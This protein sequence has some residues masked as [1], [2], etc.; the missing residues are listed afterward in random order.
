MIFPFL[1]GFLTFSRAPITWLIIFI[2][3]FLFSQNNALSRDVQIRFDSWYQNDDFLYTQG[4]VY[5]QYA[6]KRQLAQVSDNKMVGRLAFRDS[7]F[8]KVALVNNWEGDQI[9]INKW[10][11]E[12]EEFM[13]LRAYYPAIFLGLSDYQKD[14]FSYLSYQFYHDGFSHLLGNILLL[15]I[16]GG[17]L[18][19]RYSGLSIFFIYL[20]GGV[21]SAFL[22]SLTQGLGGAPVVGASGSLCALLGFL[23]A[24]EWRGKTRLFY[25]ILPAKKYMG[26]VFIPTVYWVL[27]LLM[28]DDLSGAWAQSSLFSSGVAYL[29]HI[30]GFLFGLAIGFLYQKRHV[31]LGSQL[32]E[33]LPPQELSE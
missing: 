14:F 24:V 25:M 2:N 7:H 3:V 9:A 33:L 5:K 1:D 22:Y 19:R 20:A 15:L 18:E 10:K 27:W 29:V 8:L 32:K 6:Q 30:Y 12:L 11:D 17:Y 13:V 31:L 4:Q 21:A 28:L 26:F 16:I 23:T